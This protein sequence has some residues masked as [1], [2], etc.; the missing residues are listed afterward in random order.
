MKLASFSVKY[1]SYICLLGLIVLMTRQIFA[2]ETQKTPD[3]AIISIGQVVWVKGDV[4]AIDSKNQ[5]RALQRRSDIYEHDTIVTGA[6]T[7]QIVFTDNSQVVLQK[8]T[9]LRID[10]YV[11]VPNSPSGDKSGDKYIGSLVKGGFRTITG[12]ISKSNP[13]AYEV[14]TPVATIGVR[15]TDY[16]I[17]YAPIGGLKVKLDK[18]IIFVGNKAGSI[19]LD[20]EK[21]HYYAEVKALNVN[22]VITAKP[23]AIFS[24]QPCFSNSGK[25]DGTSNCPPI[26]HVPSNAPNSTGGTSSG[27]C[28]S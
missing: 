3:A 10:Q 23:S 2:E 20:A 18:G 5:K 12:L 27:F 14:K 15:G 17:Y 9:T 24:D 13:K 26:R 8:G 6:G 28:I 16:S 11:F 1:V 21:K 4:Q 22:P 25:K 7:G 19:E